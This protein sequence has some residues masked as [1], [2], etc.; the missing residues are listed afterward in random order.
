[1]EREESFQ[2][3]ASAPG[4]GV[5]I[6]E[7]HPARVIDYAILIGLNNTIALHGMRCRVA[8]IALSERSNRSLRR[9]K[10]QKSFAFQ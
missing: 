5:K 8:L 10:S 1:M 4:E 3:L 9:N 6:I 2:V 7:M